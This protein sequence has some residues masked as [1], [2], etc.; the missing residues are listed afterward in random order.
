MSS[1]AVVILNWNGKHLLEQFI[2]PLLKYTQRNDT[3]IVVAD[4]G[5]DDDSVSF[6]KA[7]YPAVKILALGRNYGFAGGY[8]HAL[9]QIEAEYFVLLNSDVE[10]TPGWLDPLIRFMD[11]HPDAGAC[12]PKIKSLREKTMFEYAGAAG[13]FIDKY[14]YPFCRG[15]ILHVVEK[16]RGQYDSVRKIFW[17]SGAC[18][19]VR[20]EAYR[21]LG[22]LDIDFFAHMEEI[23]LCWRM[24]HA[25]Y[26]VYVIPVSVVY[27]MG[28]TS[29]RQGNPRKTYLNFRNDLLLLYKNLPS[30]RLWKVLLI[31]VILDGIAAVKF[32]FE[33]RFRHHIAVWKAHIFFWGHLKMLRV[34][35][36]N[37]LP[38]D[39]TISPDGIYQRS[40]VF[41]FYIQGKRTFSSLDYTG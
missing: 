20:A 41:R 1:I 28:G 40:I 2:P 16:D 3:G 6:I 38:P 24:Q 18:L 17:A 34:K 9:T 15:R 5:S 39:R 21:S 11:A 33:L 14:G 37:I 22:G 27:H 13:G 19:M 10:V 32:L 7:N 12:M 30:R 23:D 35:R 26:S 36:K 29:L 8:N 25:G 4:N 31:R